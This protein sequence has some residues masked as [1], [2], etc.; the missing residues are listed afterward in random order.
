MHFLLA[1]NEFLITVK[2]MIISQLIFSF[3]K[4]HQAPD[5][6]STSCNNCKI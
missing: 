5:I 3:I 4:F 1:S 2:D 6:I